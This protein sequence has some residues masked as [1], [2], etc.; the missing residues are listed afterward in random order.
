[1]FTFY[2]KKVELP[3]T[4]A[5]WSCPLRPVAQG[6][7]VTTLLFLYSHMPMT[8]TANTAPPMAPANITIRWWFLEEWSGTG[9][10]DGDGET[11]DSGVKVVWGLC[12]GAKNDFVED[13]GGSDEEDGEEEGSEAGEEGKVGLSIWL[14]E[15]GSAG[16]VILLVGRGEA[17]TCCSIRCTEFLSWE[18]FLQ[19]D[20][21][22]T[23]LENEIRKFTALCYK[24][25]F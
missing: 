5:F 7:T 22:K 1:M 17:E 14:R 11:V 18:S 2:N 21:N 3:V 12:G 13:D 20:K 4:N 25:Q 8:K 16:N 15:N 9:I 6:L 24:K 10:W 19:K 23:K